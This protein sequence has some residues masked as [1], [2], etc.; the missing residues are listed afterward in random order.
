MAELDLEELV[1][2]IIPDA[3]IFADDAEHVADLRRRASL[4]YTKL[5]GQESSR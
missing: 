3:V 1:R 4:T 2:A 5:G